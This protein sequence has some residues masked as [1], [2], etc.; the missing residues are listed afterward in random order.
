MPNF[1]KILSGRVT[2]GSHRDAVEVSSFNLLS[3]QLTKIKYANGYQELISML[4]TEIERVQGMPSGHKELTE[5]LEMVK[6][7]QTKLESD[8]QGYPPPK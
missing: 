5:F 3:A 2:S 8:V 7:L 4:L 1:E 6:P